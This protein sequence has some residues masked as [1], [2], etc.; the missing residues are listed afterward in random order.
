MKQCKDC[1]ELKELSEFPTYFGDKPRKTSHKVR[2]K[3][4]DKIKRRNYERNRDSDIK[5]KLSEYKRKLRIN[6]KQYFI[7]QFGN[8]CADC[9]NTYPACAYD[10]HHNNP[11]TKDIDPGLLF[12]RKLSAIAAELTKCVMLCANCHR[13]RHWKAGDLGEAKAYR[14]ARKRVEDESHY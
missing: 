13:I 5:K 3:I 12:A 10:F 4:C 11:N 9:N 1:G 2:C 14:N 8:K 7:E 6:N